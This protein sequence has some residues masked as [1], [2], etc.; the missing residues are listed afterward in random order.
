VIGELG[1]DKTPLATIIINNHNY[2]RFLPDAIESAL[3]QTYRR[4]EVI[5]VDDGSTDDSR[6]IIARYGGR[7]TP[8]LQE[9]GGQDS[10]FNAGFAVSRGQAICFLDADD[11]LTLAAVER[12][13]EC[14]DDPDVVKVHWPLWIADEHG[15]TTGRRMPDLELAEGDL[16]DLVVRY[17]P[18]S[19]VSAPT[20]ANVWA[21]H[22][23]DRLVPVRR[24]ALPSGTVEAYLSMV[25][26]LYGR[27]ARVP[28]PQGFYR[29]H[30]QNRYAGR[31]LEKLPLILQDYEHDARVLSRLLAERGIIADSAAWRRHSWFHRLQQVLADI[32]AAVPRA[33][34]FILIDADQLGLPRVLAG[35]PQVPFCERDGEYW[36]PPTDAAAAIHEL[37]RLRSSGASFVVVAW[38]AFWWLDHY[39]GL[40]RHLRSAFRCVMDNDRLV[41]FDL[42][43][44]STSIQGSREGSEQSHETRCPQAREPAYDAGI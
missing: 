3:G 26:P 2:G 6:E 19:Y 30:G 38:P 8:V 16:I 5:V 41:V 32:E 28:E 10:A 33:H 7:V 40:H 20:S 44:E 36:G 14:L 9:N 18:Y 22:L 24:G 34:T 39:A 23:V 25:A 35:R 13:V 17:G 12:A 21:R 37:E 15:G 29:I 1:V 4:T 43:S 42:R 31:A 27:V 11:W